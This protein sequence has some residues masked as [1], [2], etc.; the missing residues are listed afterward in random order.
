AVNRPGG[1]TEVDIRVDNLTLNGNAVAQ[2]NGYIQLYVYVLFKCVQGMARLAAPNANGII[3]IPAANDFKPNSHGGQLNS[4]IHELGHAM[5]MNANPAETQVDSHQYHY[6]FNGNHCRSGLAKTEN[7]DGPSY[8]I[9]ANEN[10][11]GLCVMFG[12]TSDTNP[13]SQFCAEC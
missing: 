5:G 11:P 2:Q 9:E 10:K 12:F 3:Y 4:I 6:E 7:N 8:Q 13:R 1:Y